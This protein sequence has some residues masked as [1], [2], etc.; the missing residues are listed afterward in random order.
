MAKC[1]RR[2]IGV[3]LALLLC[4]MF[5]WWNNWRIVTETVFVPVADLA[6]GLSGM[7]IAVLSDLHDRVFGRHNTRLIAAVAKAEP[8]LIA[9]CG[10]LADTGYQPDEVQTL[11]EQL[12][13][14]APVF[15]VTGNHEWAAGIVPELTRQ[16]EA[17]GVTVLANDYRLITRNSASLVLAGVHDPN[18]P[19]DMK[20]PQQLVEQIR[21]CA[22]TDT[23]ASSDGRAL[24]AC[25]DRAGSGGRN[26]LRDSTGRDTPVWQSAGALG[27]SFV[28]SI[29]HRL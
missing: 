5:T 9:L 24:E 17:C 1:N 11:A 2:R 27:E 28:F 20:T 8:D 7:R 15:Y 25:L 26:T 3:L 4:L 22:D 29:H 13:Q 10:D 6:E 12:S 14:I 16:L 21:S 19:Y 18:G 23:A